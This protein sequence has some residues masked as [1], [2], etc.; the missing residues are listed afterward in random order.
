MLLCCYTIL[1]EGFWVRIV[2]RFLLGN[3]L[4][5]K[6]C[7]STSVTVMWPVPA[8][9]V[10]LER[11]HNSCTIWNL[12]NCPHDFI[13]CRIFFWRFSRSSDS[14]A[15]N[16]RPFLWCK[17]IGIDKRHRKLSSVR[18]RERPKLFLLIS[19]VTETITESGIQVS[20]ETK[21]SN[22][23]SYV[24]TKTGTATRTT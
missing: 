18:P 17:I 23:T 1:H 19:A 14:L 5:R 24:E 20:V 7:R 6:P 22:G 12:M 3:E 21:I 15:E 2:Y 13:G 11:I 8:C 9:W 16:N 4:L 10:H